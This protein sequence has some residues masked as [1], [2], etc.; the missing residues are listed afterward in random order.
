MSESYVYAISDGV[1]I[2]VGVARHP[3]K[4]V[5]TLSTGNA[6]KLRL[7]GYF[8]GGFKVEKEIHRA[9][10]KVRDNGEWLYA[11]IELVSY[12]NE[13]ISDKHIVIEDGKVK[14]YLKIS[15]SMP[16]NP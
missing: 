16:H 8:S 11:T 12:L 4:R 6:N 1:N 5:K 2:K 15:T 7:L 9:H 10:T 14:A 3:E 13:M